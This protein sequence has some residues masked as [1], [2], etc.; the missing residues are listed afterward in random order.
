MVEEKLT[1]L[2][3][4]FLNAILPVTFTPVP[5]VT[6]ERAV[7]SSNA[8]VPIVVTLSGILIDLSEVHPL[9]AA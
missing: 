6:V 4:E 3:P 2:T 1:L 5:K 9:K 7:Q 8:E